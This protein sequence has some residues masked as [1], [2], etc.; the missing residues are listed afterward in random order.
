M[1]IVQ[2]CAQDAKASPELQAGQCVGIEVKTVKMK[3]SRG[4]DQDQKMKLK[5][6]LEM[7]T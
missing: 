1:L 2:S 4:T 3:T 7:T 5:Y 6:C